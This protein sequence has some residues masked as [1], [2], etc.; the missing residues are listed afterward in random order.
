MSLLG[1]WT[2]TALQ[3]AVMIDRI[4]GGL[5]RPVFGW[6]SDRIGR[7]WAIFTAFAVEG[8][9]LLVLISHA[10]NP[11]IFVVMSG[12]AFFGWG[13]VFSLFPATAGDLFG[14]KFATTNNGML[15]TAS[16]ES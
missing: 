3:L 4:M 16:T 11:V 7:E 2:L 8:L 14:R 6:I 12:I 15:Y 10:S 5:T 9:A 1:F 13:A